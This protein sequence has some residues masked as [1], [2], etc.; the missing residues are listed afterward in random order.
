M[1]WA[2]QTD[3]KDWA[4]VLLSPLFFL[5]VMLEWLHFRRADRQRANPIYEWRDSMDSMTLGGVYTFLDVLIVITLVLPAMLWAHQY[6]LAT[7]DI[8]PWT[9][10]ALYVGVEFCYY[11]FHR[12]SHRVRWFWCAHVVHHGSEHMNFTAAMRQ[13][14]LVCSMGMRA[15]GV[16]SACAVM[17][18]CSRMPS[19]S[20]PHETRVRWMTPTQLAREVGDRCMARRA[21]REPDY[22]APPCAV[23]RGLSRPVVAVAGRPSRLARTKVPKSLKRMPIA[24][25]TGLTFAAVIWR[26]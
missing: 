21:G 22:A 8:T 12:A 26:M 13:S 17:P 19:A 4:L 3:L 16:C 11:W 25:I 18:A 23:A 15:C 10:A 6:R 20:Q 9:F 24:F 5:T 1:H 14:W 2:T 7:I